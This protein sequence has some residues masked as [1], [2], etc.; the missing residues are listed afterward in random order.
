M[1]GIGGFGGGFSPGFRGFSGSFLHVAPSGHFANGSHRQFFPRRQFFAAQHFHGLRKGQVLAPTGV[2]FGGD[3]WSWP[4]TGQ[5]V[6][7]AP[8]P[9]EPVQPEVIVLQSDSNGPKVAE[10]A[11][12]YGYVAGCHAIPNGYHCDAGSTAR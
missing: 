8:P 4:D 9:E 11:P 1:G 2:L 3:Y 12:D 7:Y 5:V 10:A 6:T